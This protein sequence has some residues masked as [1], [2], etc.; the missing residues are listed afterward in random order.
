MAFRLGPFAAGFSKFAG[1]VMEANEKKKAEQMMLEDRLA[2]KEERDARRK[3]SEAAA[4]SAAISLEARLRG[5]GYVPEGEI[6]PGADKPV[7]VKGESLD[8][9]VGALSPGMGLT[10]GLQDMTAERYGKSVGGYRYDKNSDAARRSRAQTEKAERDARPVPQG[11]KAPVPGT[12]EY[13]AMREK[14]AQIESRYRPPR[15]PRPAPQPADGERKAA[16]MLERIRGVSADLAQFDSQGTLDAL[17]GK[18]GMMGNWTTSPEG[19][20]LRAAGRIWV[21]SVLRPESGATIGDKELDNYFETYLPRPGDDEITLA[22]KRRQ[23]EVAERAVAVQAGRA[24]SGN[25][26]SDDDFTTEELAAAYNAGKQT[27]AEIAAWIKANRQQ[28]R[29]PR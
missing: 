29:I 9:L 24:I 2:Q 28:P 23:R 11:P 3:A 22:F 4:Q 14:E 7:T 17:S 10:A 26:Q 12:P 1:G 21:M 20:R 13:F 18:A 27:D 19:R 8:A 16:A 6:A 25:G 15:E 5:D